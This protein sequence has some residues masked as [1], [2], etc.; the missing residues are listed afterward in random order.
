MTLKSNQEKQK[1]L[2]TQFYLKDV[3]LQFVYTQNIDTESHLKLLYYCNQQKIKNYLVLEDDITFLNPLKKLPPFPDQYD[4][5]SLGGD[6]VGVFKESNINSPWK[7]TLARTRHAYIMNSSIYSFVLSL[8]NNPL[9]LRMDYDQFLIENVEPNVKFFSLNPKMVIKNKRYQHHVHKW[10]DY[11]NYMKDASIVKYE[12]NHNKEKTLFVDNVYAIN[13]FRRQDRAKLFA[14][15]AGKMGFRH[16]LWTAYDGNELELTDHIKTIIEGNDFNNKG[17]VLG[18]LLSHL[19][20]W[21][22]LAASNVLNEIIIFEDDV[23]FYDGFVNNWKQC[24]TELKTVCPDYD[25]CYLGGE[26]ST[27]DRP[28]GEFATTH[29]TV[30]LRQN[31]LGLYGYCLSKHGAKKLVELADKKKI[32]RAIDWWVVDQFDEL[33]V[34]MCHPRLVITETSYDSDIF[35]NFKNLEDGNYY[36]S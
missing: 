8:I 36:I 20:L 21:T 28:N 16:A 35:F 29:L 3:N 33:K 14:N 2:M 32:T 23:E 18:C 15:E 27:I 17:G 7:K 31:H 9:M 34:F 5:L 25:I 13:L 4:M 22:F 30:P 19:D 24:Y 6:T 10:L 11:N 26:V 1:R 12:L